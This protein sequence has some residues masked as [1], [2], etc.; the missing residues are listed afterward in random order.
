MTFSVGRKLFATL[1]ALH[2]KMFRKSF[3]QSMLHT[4]DEAVEEFGI[5]W[6]LQDCFFSLTRQHWACRF[7]EDYEGVPCHVAGLRSGVYPFIGP[8]HLNAV[9]FLLATALSF[10]LYL[11]VRPG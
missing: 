10:V 6:L 2:P 9:K 11:F 3:A 1:V 5:F 8:S 4:F 7:E